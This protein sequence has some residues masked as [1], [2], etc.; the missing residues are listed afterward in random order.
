MGI[1][2]RQQYARMGQAK[3][4]DQIL[5]NDAQRAHQA[6]LRNRCGNI[7]QRQV[8]SGQSDAQHAMPACAGQHHH[9]LWRRRFFS[10]VF[11]VTCKRKASVI[12]DTFLY[13]RRDDRVNFT[14]HR[15]GNGRTQ[16]A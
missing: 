6:V 7:F 15:S 16:H 14:R 4:P 11:S 12:D 13:R 9:H 10:K 1:E 2:S 5:M 3:M 8:R